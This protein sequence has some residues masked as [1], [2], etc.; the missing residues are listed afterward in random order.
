MEA[1]EMIKKNL[2]GGGKCSRM[3][4]FL[5]DNTLIPKTFDNDIKICR[6]WKNEMT[7]HFNDENEFMKDAWTR[8]QSWTHH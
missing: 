8:W 3:S 1:E 7:K 5:L 4:G 2:G 6:K